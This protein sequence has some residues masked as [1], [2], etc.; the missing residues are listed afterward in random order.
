MAGPASSGIVAPMPPGYLEQDSSLPLFSVSLLLMVLQS[1]FVA[2]FFVSRILS[3]NMR[4]LEFWVFLP[5]AYVFCMAHCING[6]S[7]SIMG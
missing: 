1:I 2:I 3:K 5:A 4:G 7:K 6:I